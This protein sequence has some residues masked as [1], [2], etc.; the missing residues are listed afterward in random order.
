M[1]P[2]VRSIN[3][4]FP[5]RRRTG[6]PRRCLRDAWLSDHFERD[7]LAAPSRGR[8]KIRIDNENR[9]DSDRKRSR[10]GFPLSLKGEP[11][12]LRRAELGA[13]AIARLHQP[14]K[15]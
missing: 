8:L 14:I 5:G 15:G 3:D 12:L 1:R 13:H 7:K 4:I 6:A 2:L 9:A 10:Q 11:F